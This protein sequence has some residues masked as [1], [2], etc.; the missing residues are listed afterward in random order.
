M[1]YQNLEFSEA[2]NFG[3][4]Q[5]FGIFFKLGLHSYTQVVD[6]FFA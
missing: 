5:K 4:P 2:P 1:F 6:E 3:D